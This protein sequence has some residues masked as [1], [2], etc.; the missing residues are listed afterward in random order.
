MVASTKNRR[1]RETWIAI[2]AAW[3]VCGAEAIASDWPIYRGPNH[4]G[5]SDEVDWQ[6][7]WGDAGPKVLWRASVGTGSSSVVTAD[8]R[9]YTMGNHGEEEDQQEDTVYCLDAE[10]GEMRWKHT[11]PLPTAA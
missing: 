10:T 11:Y 8:G 6:S 3:L 1:V 4:N 7:D 9:A 5:I 2:T